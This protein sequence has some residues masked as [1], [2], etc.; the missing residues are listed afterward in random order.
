MR[1]SSGGTC[2][3][4]A[5]AG[6]RLVLLCSPATPSCGLQSDLPT[7]RFHASSNVYVNIRWCVLWQHSP[8]LSMLE[9]NLAVV[10]SEEGGQD[11]TRSRTPRPEAAQPRRRSGRTGGSGRASPSIAD[12]AEVAGVSAQTVSRVSTDFAGV[13]PATR[14]RVQEA[15]RQVG[16]VPNSAARA[17]KRGSFR[18]IGIVAH[19][20]A[21]TGES[22]T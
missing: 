19:Q 20:L 14:A 1:A 15:M 12:V 9:G 3:E 5:R 17:L 22:S 4:P 18:T 10:D 16:Y 7:F 13:R 2:A 21:R 11:T 8:H 6:R